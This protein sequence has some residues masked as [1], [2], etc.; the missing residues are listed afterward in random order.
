MIEQ[1]DARF[2]ES[3]QAAFREGDTNTASKLEEAENVSRV[4]Q[5]IHIIARQ[6]FE[7]LE[8]MLADD[9][10]LDIIGSAENP[11]VGKWQGRQQVIDATRKNFALLED[12][13]PEI[14]SVVAQG[15][16]VVVVARERGRF[17]ETG[18]DYDFHWVQLYTFKENEL[19]RIRELLAV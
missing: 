7:A 15:D 18:R 16:T 9:V 11:I 6:D 14:E 12:Q 5:L 4:E 17:A 13:R 1:I 19:A 10:V 8:G 2:F 3:L